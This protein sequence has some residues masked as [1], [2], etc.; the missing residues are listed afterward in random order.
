[1]QIT[2]T[3]FPGVK[4]IR[5]DQFIDERGHLEIQMKKED[6]EKAGL[7]TEWVQQNV[8]HSFQNVIRGMHMQRNNPQGKLI[9]C[10]AGTIQDAWVDLRP[11][12]PTFKRWGTYQLSMADPEALYL[13]PGIAHGF[14]TISSF[15]VV[16]YLCNTAYDKDSDG[17]IR[18]DD[19]G[20]GIIWAM[21][22]G[23]VPMVSAK[24]KALPT[25]DEFLK[26][27]G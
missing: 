7:P 8:S 12:S 1:M 11:D 17:G 16:H 27:L 24:D 9:K 20:V 15:S 19:P 13:P 4:I 25:M 6:Y 26:S 5:A 18:W 3:P 22:T 23:T 14:L 10:V 21:E 2:E